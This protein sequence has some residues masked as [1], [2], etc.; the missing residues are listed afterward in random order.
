MEWHI[1]YAVDHNYILQCAVSCY[2]FVKNLNAETD[3]Y[4]HVLIDETVTENDRGLFEKIEYHFPHISFCFHLVSDEFLNW[5]D[6]SFSYLNKMTYYRLL[7][8]ELLDDV[9]Q[10]LY[11]DSDT[12]LIGDISPLLQYDIQNDY[13]AGVRDSGIKG[14]DYSLDELDGMDHYINAGVLLMNLKALRVDGMQNQFCNRIANRYQFNDQDILNICCKDRIH[15]LPEKYNCFSYRKEKVDSA[16]LIHFLGEPGMRPW[17]YKRSKDGDLWWEYA[18]F[19]QEFPIYEKCKEHMERFYNSGSPAYI[20]E[21]CKKSERI[22]IWGAGEY[23]FDLYRHLKVNQVPNVAAFIDNNPLK[24]G[25]RMN[26]IDIIMP[27]ALLY[28]KGVLVIIAVQS[29]DGKKEILNLLKDRGFSEKEVI[30]YRPRESG[31]FAYMDSRY[32]EKEKEEAF[33]W[34]YG[35]IKERE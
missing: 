7:L 4:I 34:A 8:P 22:Y 13:L 20:L 21:S 2:S 35:Q 12:L 32:I 24:K 1:V 14:I 6:F 31:F 25:I 18:A 15:F 23:G 5:M 30:Y 27:D 19:F 9:E 11:I 3:S 16:V 26:N 17:I 28:E 33:T 29:Q 10:C